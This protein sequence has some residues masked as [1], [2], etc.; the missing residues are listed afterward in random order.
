MRLKTICEIADGLAPF[1]LS[2]EY[3]EK[4][5]AH[6]NSG[7]QLDCGGE[8]R[9]I[10]F[11]LD[12]SSEAV[13]RAKAFGADCVFTH[14]PAIYRPLYSLEE[15]GVGKQVLACA[16][17]G[18][19]IVSA[20]LN[21]DAAEGGIDDCLMR[22]LGGE[23]AECVMHSL[24]GGGYGRIS[25]I[26][27]V[28]PEVFLKRIEREFGARRVLFYA[29]DRRVARIASFCGAG[30]DDETV[31]FAI[32][33]GADTFVSS[34]PKHHLIAALA[35]A[36]LNVVILTHYAA[37]NYGFRKFYEKF[38]NESKETGIRTEYFSDERF[39]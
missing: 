31:A 38:E 6:D 2:R 18:I 20:H 1:A 29:G 39:L 30:T 35:E 10:L 36:G 17:A 37:E 21:L 15:A 25:E 7:V 4:Y 13:A 33:H 16:R 27:P 34:D 11:S 14:H 12:L 5:G 19:S 9:R 3:C 22:G 24:T 8:I 32:S 26:A 28:G 23:A